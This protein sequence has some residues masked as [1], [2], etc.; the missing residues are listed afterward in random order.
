MNEVNPNIALGQ[1][2]Q[3]VADHKKKPPQAEEPAGAGGW[4]EVNQ[5]R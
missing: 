1:T 3:P 5:K 2:P 4:S